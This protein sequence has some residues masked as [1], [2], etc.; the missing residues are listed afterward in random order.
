MGASRVA[1]ISVSRHA[2]ALTPVGPQVGSSL[3][4]WNLR[5]RP[6]PSSCWV[7]SHIEL[8]RGLLGVHVSYGLPARGAAFAALSI[9]G[10]GSFVTSTTAPI[11]TGWSNSCRVGIA[12]T[13]D[14]HLCTAHKRTQLLFFPYSSLILPGCSRCRRIPPAIERVA[15][16]I[17]WLLGNSGLYNKVC[18]SVMGT[19]ID[20]QV[21]VQFLCNWWAFGVQFLCMKWGDHV[22]VHANQFCCPGRAAAI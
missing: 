1:P 20:G 8:F 2:V 11:A 21:G 22:H 4:P 3:L 16:S 13:E 17:G 14:R 12:P 18:T 15:G 7:G 19:S 9:E 10:F 6:S 5:R